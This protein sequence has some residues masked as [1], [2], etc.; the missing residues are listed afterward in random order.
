MTL[1][2]LIATVM[3]LAAALVIAWP[4]LRGGHRRLAPAI[5]AFLVLLLS[6]FLYT[7]WSTWDWSGQK[8]VPPEGAQIAAMVSRLE[9]KLEANP[10]DLQG[11]L[12]L[13]RSYLTLER[14]DDAIAAYDHAVRLGD[15][16]DAESLLGM[17]EAMSMRAGGRI[18]PPAAQM[19]ESALKLAPQNPRALLYGGFAAAS[20]GDSEQAR[21]R[22]EALKALNP[23]PQLVQMLDARIA[24]LQ[25][26]A[27]GASAA[28]PATADAAPATAGAETATATVS[29]KISAALSTRA[30][31]DSTVYIFASE[32]DVRGPPLAVKRLQVSDLS[33]PISLS[34][35]DSMVPGRTL[36]SGQSVRIAA[37]VSFSGQPTPSTGDLYGELTYNVGQDGTRDLI[38]DRVAE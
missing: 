10:N 36:R 9:T 32:P 17:G 12:M 16:K 24:E 29:V 21:S 27:P 3:A 30:K 8:Q 4:L 20:R 22:W 19:F 35:G 31:P 11:W 5:A 25:M 14:F 18:I 28:A 1:F 26:Q 15:G 33:A 23:P 34:A 38:I 2:I 37:R 7:R 13:G 6:G